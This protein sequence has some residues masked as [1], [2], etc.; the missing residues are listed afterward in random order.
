MLIL[1][2]I[3]QSDRSI[4]NGCRWKRLFFFSDDKTT[5][6]CI[7]PVGVDTGI[8]GRKL[9]CASLSSRHPCRS[10]DEET[11][12]ARCRIRHH[13]TARCGGGAVITAVSSHIHQLSMT[14]RHESA[15]P[16]HSL[17]DGKRRRRRRRRIA[18]YIIRA[19]LSRIRAM[20]DISIWR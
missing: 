17:R 8:F 16:G 19:R 14:R 4:F 9:Q 3:F 5:R 18:H 13:R 6:G 11:K 12:R 10:S 20:L 1:R 15:A 2:S 7:A